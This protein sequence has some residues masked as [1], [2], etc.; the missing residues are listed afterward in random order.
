MFNAILIV[1]SLSVSLF[2]KSGFV[3]GAI[4]PRGIRKGK[5]AETPIQYRLNTVKIYKDSKEL[6]YVQ[7]IYHIKSGLICGKEV[8]EAWVLE[9]DY[10]SIKR[11]LLGG[12]FM[13]FVGK[14]TEK[15]YIWL[16]KEGAVGYG[17]N[18]NVFPLKRGL[19]LHGGVR[20][21]AVTAEHGLYYDTEWDL[22]FEVS[23]LGDSASLIFSI[24]DTDE[25]RKLLNDPLSTGGFSSLELEP[26]KNYP[27]TNAN[28]IFKVTLK[29]G[30][31]FTVENMTDKIF[32]VKPGCLKPGRSRK[33]PKLSRTR[34]NAASRATGVC[35][36][37][38]LG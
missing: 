14:E 8:V 30:E 17:A 22:D 32:S 3:E 26:M 7:D 18:S 10:L 13:G 34:R 20:M 11:V 31:K 25:A 5:V 2:K 15:E 38:T 1:L 24:Q 35:L 23:L 33:T 6:T 28:F 16:N 19:F 36:S 27:T 21:A 37:M 12:N 29:K 4:P 9:N